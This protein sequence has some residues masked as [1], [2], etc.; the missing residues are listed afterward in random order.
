V[1]A[2]RNPKQYFSALCEYHGEGLVKKEPLRR[3]R[4]DESMWAGIVEE[5]SQRSNH[6]GRIIDE[7]SC[8]RIMDE[9]SLRRNH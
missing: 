7:E 5:E 3:N 1:T 8:R 9:K 6:R 4:G 2:R